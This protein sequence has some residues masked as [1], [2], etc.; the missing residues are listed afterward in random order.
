MLI[1]SKR[2][3]ALAASLALIAVDK[4]AAGTSSRYETFLFGAA[5]YPKQWPESYW[6]DDASRMRECGVNVVRMGEFEQVE[7]AGKWILGHPL[8]DPRR[9]SVEGTAQIERIQG[10]ENPGGRRA[11]EHGSSPG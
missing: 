2:F 10:D 3:L 9:E 8:L 6:E 4:A 5:Y 11:G 7:V 1:P